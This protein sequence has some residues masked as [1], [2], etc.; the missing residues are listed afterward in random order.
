LERG[1]DIKKRGGAPLKLPF[2]R[3][4]ERYRIEGVPL[5]SS[6]IKNSSI[7][8]SSGR[9]FRE[10]ALPPLTTLPLP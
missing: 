9:D 4:G 7:K 1:K 10:G 8:N 2:S 6:L 5:Q 3:E